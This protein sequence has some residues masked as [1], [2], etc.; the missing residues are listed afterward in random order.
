DWGDLALS[1]KILLVEETESRPAIS[2]R[3]SVVLPNSSKTKGIGTDTTRFY[4]ALLLGKK[5]GSAYVFGNIGIAILDDPTRVAAQQDLL[6]YGIA[7]SIPAGTRFNVMAEWNGRHSSTSNPTPGGESLGQARLGFQVKAGGIRWDAAA[8]AGTT[9]WDHNIGFV[10]GLSK[11][12]Q[13]FR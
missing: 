3:P 8:T 5:A 4:G 2:F 13:L 11:E 1:T 10:A 9:H 6:T 7:T 12:F